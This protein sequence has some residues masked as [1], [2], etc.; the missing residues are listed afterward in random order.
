MRNPSNG[1]VF[2]KVG[3]EMKAEVAGYRGGHPFVILD[4][5]EDALLSGSYPEVGATLHVIVETASNA[6]EQFKR[7]RNIVVVEIQES[8]ST[9]QVWRAPETPAVPKFAAQVR[10]ADGRIVQVERKRRRT[11]LPQPEAS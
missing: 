2:A 10:A 6:Y 5:G 11:F 4:T 3:D 8:V 9:P 7:S 1:G